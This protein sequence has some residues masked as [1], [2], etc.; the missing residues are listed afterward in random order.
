MRNKTPALPGRRF[1]VLFAL[2][3][4]T[5]GSSKGSGGSSGIQDQTCE[6]KFNVPLK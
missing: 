1:A 6:I 3:A 4:S 5:R 2:A